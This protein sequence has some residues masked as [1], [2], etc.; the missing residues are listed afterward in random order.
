MKRKA[1]LLPIL[2]PFL[3]PLRKHTGS[4]IY[5]AQRHVGRDSESNYSPHFTKKAT[6]APGVNYGLGCDF[7][8][9]LT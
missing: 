7:D 4:F 5:R 6:Q 3:S 1:K 8:P 2:S 9:E